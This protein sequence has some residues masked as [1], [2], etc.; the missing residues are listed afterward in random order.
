MTDRKGA[1]ECVF[2]PGQQLHVAAEGLVVGDEGEHFLIVLGQA[3]TS[4]FD[5]VLE[6]RVNNLNVSRNCHVTDR[7]QLC[8]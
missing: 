5:D 8:G 1:Q 2:V 3:A 7:S 6:R 4:F